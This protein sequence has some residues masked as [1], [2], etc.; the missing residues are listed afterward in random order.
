MKRAWTGQQPQLRPLTGYLGGNTRVTHYRGLK[1]LIIIV[2]TVGHANNQVTIEAGGSSLTV[3]WGDGNQYTYPNGV[4]SYTYEEPGEYT[5]IIY[6]GTLFSLG[7]I[8]GGIGDNPDNA[9]KLKEIVSFGDYELKRLAIGQ[10]TD[11][12]ILPKTLPASVTSLSRVLDSSVNISPNITY[13]DTSH[14]TN[15][16]YAFTQSDLSD[17][18]YVDIT[19]WNTSSATHLHYMFRLCEDFNQDI[20]HWDV[21]KV[22]NMSHLFSVTKFN[23][24]IGGWDVS[25]VTDMSSL[26]YGT[27]FSYDLN[28]WDVSSVQQI[29][30]IFG[31]STFNGNIS[32]WNIS[33]MTNLI[34]MFY[35]N[36]AFNGDITGW[37]VS[38]TTHMF[39]M[40]NGASAFNRDI[41]NWD[42]S[43]VI[44]MNNMFNNATVFNQDLTGWD[45]AHIETEPTNFS[46]NSA[47]IEENKPL[48]GQ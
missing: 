41:G 33:S 29:T 7:N 46:T 43:N 18:S 1:P 19:G 21:S 32:G 10:H 20:S 15:F 5:I 26:F 37:D 24:D 14:V 8:S 23:Y 2:D 28:E 11:G 30:Y 4:W 13:W 48:W 44:S 27:N 9:K 36:T 39:N 3:D 42:V 12:L 31:D 25:S 45:V 17:S 47:L 6:G 35:N 40:F 22:Q 34:G 38:S 16:S